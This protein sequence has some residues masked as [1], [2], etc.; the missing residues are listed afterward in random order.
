MKVIPIGKGGVTLDPE[1]SKQWYEANKDEKKEY[2]KKQYK[3][4]YEANKGKIKEY[5][6]VNKEK[7]KQQMKEWYEA[8]KDEKKEY[9]K[10]QYKQWYEANKE[11]RKEYDKQ[12]YL[13][14]QLCN[15]H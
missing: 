12:R 1:Y 7:I 8:N 4:W 15:K 5:K 11:K 10:K 9:Y 14:Q 6:E 13:N 3:Q 2:Y